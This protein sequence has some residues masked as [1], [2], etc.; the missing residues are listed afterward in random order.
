MAQLRRYDVMPVGEKRRRRILGNTGIL[1][2]GAVFIVG[3]RLWFLATGQGLCIVMCVVLM[4]L[5]GKK[6]S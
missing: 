4:A 2:D 1:I 5:D 6:S 3:N